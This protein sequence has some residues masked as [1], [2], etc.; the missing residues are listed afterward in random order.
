MGRRHQVSI[1]EELVATRKHFPFPSD[2]R[3]RGHFHAAT[4]PVHLARLKGRRAGDGG[5]TGS[6]WLSVVGRGES[7]QGGS[8]VAL[9]IYYD[10]PLRRLRLL[11][12]QRHVPYQ[13]KSRLVGSA[14]LS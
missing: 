2:S 4:D 13:H 1:T 10:F 8:D 3:T 14:L 9:F 11:W 12:S 6:W 5:S 7:W